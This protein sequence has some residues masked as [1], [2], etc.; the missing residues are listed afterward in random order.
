MPHPSPIWAAS[1]GYNPELALCEAV[2]R[3]LLLDAG[4]RSD[5]VRRDIV[6]FLADDF[7]LGFWTDLADLGPG[8]LAATV[9]RA[10][11]G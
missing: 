11:Q 3:Q 7:W 9:Q 5:V 8:V 2:F 4:S 1:E 10:M 6:K